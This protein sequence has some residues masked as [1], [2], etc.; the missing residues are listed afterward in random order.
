MNKSGTILSVA[1]AILVIVCPTIACRNDSVSRDVFAIRTEKL[2]SLEKIQLK[3]A[4]ALYSGW[5]I[6]DQVKITMQYGDT[7]KPCPIDVSKP[8]V[9]VEYQVKGSDGKSDF[10]WE[11]QPNIND[12]GCLLEFANFKGNETEGQEE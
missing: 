3:G 7:N 11:L 2:H 9:L 1:L 5:T 8:A 6:D 4:A 10:G 12:A